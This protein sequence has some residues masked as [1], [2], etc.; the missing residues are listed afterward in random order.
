MIPGPSAATR[1]RSMTATALAVD[2]A[3]LI[4]LDL[5]AD[6]CTVEPPVIRASTWL[7]S[8]LWTRATAIDDG[9]AAAEAAAEGADAGAALDAARL[10]GQDADRRGAVAGT[11]GAAA[12]TDVGAVAD[13]GE[14]D[15]VDLVDRLGA[16]TVMFTVK[17]PAP[18]VTVRATATTVALIVGSPTLGPGVGG[19][20]DPTD[21][22]DRRGID[23]GHDR[24]GERVLRRCARTVQADAD[25]A[26]RDAEGEVGGDDRGDER[27]DG[28]GVDLDVPPAATVVVA[29][30]I[31]ARMSSRTSLVGDGHCER[32]RRP[33]PRHLRRPNRR[34][35]RRAT[36]RLAAPVL[37]ADTSDV[38]AGGELG[39][40]GD[41]GIDVVGDRVMEIEMVNVPLM[42]APP[43]DAIETPAAAA[44]IV[45]WMLASASAMT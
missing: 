29:P 4:G 5:I 2:A 33:R 31:E 39:P 8:M 15:V 45:E 12:A 32:Q 19:D 43:D 23:A 36:T 22:G 35:R 20:G 26:G 10:D 37:P 6:A 18:A 14:H 41:V 16:A 24:V 21:T 28:A 34:A 44:T 11:A 13:R 38:A 3:D 30:S 27:D 1:S 40:V 17:E 9:A 25:T 42:V 7:C